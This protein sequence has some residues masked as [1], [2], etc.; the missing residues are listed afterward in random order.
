MAML[1]NQM[2]KKNKATV[3]SH[4]SFFP[5]NPWWSPSLQAMMKEMRG[6]ADAAS[7]SRLDQTRDF[8]GLWWFNMILWWFTRRWNMME[9]GDPI[10]TL[11]LG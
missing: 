7:F 8:M 11:T 10:T 5:A 4:G 2:V 6:Y 9:Y 1:N 3:T